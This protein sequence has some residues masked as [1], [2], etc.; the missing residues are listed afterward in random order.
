MLGPYS[1]H[2][3]NHLSLLNLCPLIEIFFSILLTS[4]KFYRIIILDGKVKCDLLE[5]KN[6]PA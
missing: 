3:L 5:S 2:V 1:D 6:L 4:L